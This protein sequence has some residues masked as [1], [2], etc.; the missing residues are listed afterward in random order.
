MAAEMDFDKVNAVLQQTFSTASAAL[1]QSL[2]SMDE[3]QAQQVVGLVSIVSA[4][5]GVYVVYKGVVLLVWIVGGVFRTV[6]AVL[7]PPKYVSYDEQMAE[8]RAALA[9]AKGEPEQKE[10]PK[11]VKKGKKGPVKNEKPVAK[12][13]DATT[14]APKEKPRQTFDIMRNKTRTRA[15]TPSSDFT[16]VKGFKAPLNTVAYSPAADLLFLGSENRTYKLYKASTIGSGSEKSVTCRLDKA[17]VT[18]AAF[19]NQG[20]CLALYYDNEDKL[21]AFNVRFDQATPLTQIWET[22]VPMVPLNSIACG[23]GAG[24]ATLL[25]DAGGI[26]VVNRSGR[27]LDTSKTSQG[28][29]RQWTVNAH[30]TMVGL[31]ASMSSSCRVMGFSSGNRSTLDKGPL[32]KGVTVEAW[33]QGSRQFYP[34]VV[35]DVD[36]DDTYTIKWTD[37]GVVTYHVPRK[38][39]KPT[40][41][42]TVGSDFSSMKPILTLSGHRN[43]LTALSFSHDGSRAVT[44]SQDGGVKLWD[45]NVRYHQKEDAHVLHA[46]NDKDFIYFTHAALSPNNK[47]LVLAA[48]DTSLLIYR[49]DS[50]APT[51]MGEITEAHKG[52]VLQSLVFTGKATVVSVAHGDNK[53]KAWNLASKPPCFKPIA[54]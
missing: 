9:R 39:L 54:E 38:E 7:F 20:T 17:T 50:K 40:G 15:P 4:V 44:A 24:Y 16:L 33:D 13:N 27:V 26:T 10:S 41:V 6:W 35:E 3:E 23:P 11:D 48:A 19:D 21:K 51:L 47:I 14:S 43:A 2:S 18:H 46:F 49:V 25:D 32:W 31:C 37:G 12:R 30:G 34:A 28:E 8:R 45:V 1:K 5:V 42:Q 36:G 22:K 52:H 29:L 53:V